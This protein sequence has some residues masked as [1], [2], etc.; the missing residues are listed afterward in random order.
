MLSY[1]RYCES[2]FVSLFCC[3]G[4]LPHVDRR[5]GTVQM[6]IGTVRIEPGNVWLGVQVLGIKGHFYC[7]NV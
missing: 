3:Y 1:S 2:V 5:N 6:V 4:Q 7:C